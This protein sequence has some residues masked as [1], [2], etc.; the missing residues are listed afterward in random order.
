VFLDSGDA[1]LHDNDSQQITF[2][3]MASTT[4][5]QR[6]EQKVKF[7]QEL[8]SLENSD[9]DRDEGLRESIETLRRH[10]AK[11]VASK[12]AEI[13]ETTRPIRNPN[14]GQS[15]PRSPKSLPRSVSDIGPVTSRKSH[16]QG[17][18]GMAARS[19]FDSPNMLSARNKASAATAPISSMPQATGKRKRESVVTLMPP[20]QRIFSGL[21]FY[22]FPNNEKHPARLMRITKAISFGATWQRDWSDCV[23]HAILDKAMDYTMLLKFLKKDRLPNAVVVVNE[24][25]PSECIAYRALLDFSRPQFKVTGAVLAAPKPPLTE[26]T[27]VSSANSDTSLKL[28]PPT[29]DARPRQRETQSPDECETELEYPLDQAAVNTDDLNIEAPEFAEMDELEAAISQARDLQHVPLDDEDGESRPSSS[30]GMTA[31]PPHDRPRGSKLT[32][33]EKFQCMQ[34]HTGEANGSPNSATTLILQQMAN[35]YGQLG[36]EWR[37][38]AYR[39]AIATLRNHPTKV[40]TKEEALALPNVGDRLATKIEEIAFTS[41]LRRLDNALAEPRDQI[42]QTFMNVYGAG[43]VHA[44]NWVR[45]GYT[46]LD[47]LLRSASLTENQKIGIEH[48]EDFQLRIPRAE[49]AKHGEIVRK[50]LHGLDPA[51]E[52]TIGGSY[53]RGAKDSGDI[54]CI[55]TCPDAGIDRVRTVVVNQL[56]PKLFQQG[57]LKAALAAT[58]GDGSKWH[59][60]SCLPGQTVWRR[61][62]FLLVPWAE[63]GAALL[64]FTGNDIFNRS[65][66]LLASTK[67]F[68]LNQRGLYKDVMRGKGREKITEGTLVEGRDERKIFAAL[69]VLWRPPEHRIV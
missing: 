45:Q 9:D 61:I 62:D 22:F 38:K 63:M 54:D 26:Q 5:E 24:S 20:D 25:W 56:V 51:F 30:D 12:E 50:T 15:R 58:S 42:L 4:E 32:F 59:G 57:F 68:R 14:T 33:Q 11:P 60:A 41:R 17:Q 44:S 7:Y 36:D 39:K 21:H 67:G 18:A 31:K 52:V 10:S 49:V 37:T 47:D 43:F 6:L 55:I 27:P 16:A 1:D 28:K 40:C 8:A 66:R 2:A 69:G 53:R 46:T 19:T 23:T 13:V 34:K 65:M 64:Y 35:Y 48:F 29:K 3:N